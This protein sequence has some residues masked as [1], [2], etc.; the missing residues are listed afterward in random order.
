LFY[1]RKQQERILTAMKFHPGKIFA[2]II[3]HIRP[4]S[5]HSSFPVKIPPTNRR[6]GMSRFSLFILWCSIF[7]PHSSFSQTLP[8]KFTRDDTLR[9]AQTPVRTCY[10]VTT[11]DLSVRVD[12]KKKS[13]SGSNVI[14]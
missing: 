12:V 6:T 1:R 7:I 9:G 2:F 13:I 8:L 5:G 14:R 10:D 3:F 11:Y 4:A